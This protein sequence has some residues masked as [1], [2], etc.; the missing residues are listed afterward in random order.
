MMAMYI[1][2]TSQRLHGFRL[3]CRNRP[4]EDQFSEDGRAQM[5]LN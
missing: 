3:K 5:G 4:I 2:G 1:A